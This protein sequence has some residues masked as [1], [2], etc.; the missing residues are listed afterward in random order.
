MSTT[1]PEREAFDVKHTKGTPYVRATVTTADGEQLIIP[2]EWYGH[3]VE[4][5]ALG[6]NVG[7]R[8]GDSSNA[9]C[10]LTTASSVTSNALTATGKEPH[11]VV[12]SGATRCE[13]IPAS[14]VKLPDNTTVISRFAHHADAS[15]GYLQMALASGDG[16]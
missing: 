4:F 2:A 6:A 14:G 10:A 8:F 5:T 15:T 16:T 11:F 9:K 1:L 12:P 3:L 7:I 13:R